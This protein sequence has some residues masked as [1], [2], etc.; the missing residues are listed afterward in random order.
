[1]TCGHFYESGQANC[2]ECG[3]RKSRRFQVTFYDPPASGN[4]TPKTALRVA[5]SP[6]RVQSKR[7][8]VRPTYLLELDEKRQ[9]TLRKVMV[10]AH[11]LDEIV[12]AYHANGWAVDRV[13]SGEIFPFLGEKDALMVVFRKPG[14]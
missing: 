2:P 9:K 10:K 12:K 5:G 7:H 3:G 11:E 8:L 14:N 13:L 4:P 6:A 1:M